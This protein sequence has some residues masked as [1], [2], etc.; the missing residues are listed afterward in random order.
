MILDKR[1]NRI[2]WHVLLA[3]RRRASVMLSVSIGL[4][5][6]GAPGD[7]WDLRWKQGHAEVGETWPGQRAIPKQLRDPGEPEAHHGGGATRATTRRLRI[8]KGQPQSHRVQLGRL[9]SRL[10]AGTPQ[11]G[12]L[13][14]EADAAWI[15]QELRSMGWWGRAWMSTVV[16][17]S[18]W[19]RMDGGMPRE[20]ISVS[21][22]DGRHLGEESVP[23]AAVPMPSREP[24][25]FHWRRGSHF[26]GGR[27]VRKTGMS[28]G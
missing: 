23:E 4:S 17:Q 22:G 9:H 15:V 26:A 8:H 13:N 12:R 6:S 27:E 28:G 24:I 7:Q 21:C 2:P 1:Q 3:S 10:R 18:G 14:I 19:T 20:P 16:P 11:A 25:W 5:R